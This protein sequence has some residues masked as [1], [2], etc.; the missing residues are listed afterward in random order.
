MVNYLA[1]PKQFASWSTD[2][3]REV[4]LRHKGERGP[5][6]E[7]LNDLQGT[8]GYIHEDA[9]AILAEELNLSQAEVYGVV[10]FY[11][12]LRTEAPGGF[13]VKIC[14][15]ESCQSVGADKL[16]ESAQEVFETKLGSTNSERSV[17]LEEVFCLG[18]CAL[19]PAIMVDEKLIG[20]MSTER[21]AELADE[22][23]GVT[24]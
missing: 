19:S 20:R 16:V 3:A 13:L 24:L 11:K 21:I 14:R 2:A 23:R 5:L 15:G 8:F 4:V 17:T 6:L 9:I 1:E 7:I 22:I 12:D 18:N 10:T